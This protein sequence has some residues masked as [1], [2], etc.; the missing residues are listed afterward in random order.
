MITTLV[1][2]D[3]R[4]LQQ[5]VARI[6]QECGFEVEVEKTISTARGQV[7]VDV[8]AE[9][10]V[11]GRN[12]MI[13]CECKL[14][15]APVHQG[16]VHAFRTVVG[17]AG[18]NLGYIVTSSGFQS[19]AFTAADMTNLRLVTWQQFQVEFEASWLEHHLVPKLA[20]DL[21]PLL[22]LTE[23]LLPGSFW[24]LDEE[25]QSKFIAMRDRY[26]EFVVL[27]LPFSPYFRLTRSLPTLPLRARIEERLDT[28][29]LPSGVLDALSYREWLEEAVTFGEKAI[30]E[31]RGALHPPSPGTGKTSE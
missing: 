2:E 19:G 20:K 7:E 13:L 28:A 22:T 1:P 16:V 15:K 18:A 14:W 11:E 30:R 24:E 31:L 5:E 29:N 21:D 6:L 25:Q 12:Y 17:D 23:P 9:E 27:I 4:D 8:Y 10:S 26:V 3:W